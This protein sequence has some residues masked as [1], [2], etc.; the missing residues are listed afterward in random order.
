M[1]ALLNF[2]LST[3]LLLAPLMTCVGVG[4]Y[5]GR[6][7][8]PFGGPFITILVTTVTTPA[9]VFHT[10]ATTRIESALWVDLVGGTLLALLLCALLSALALRLCRL[11]VRNLL[12]TASMPNAG[13]LGLPLAYL[14][15][16]DI[17]LSA[18]VVFFAVTSF[19]QNTVM[20][21]MLSGS[22]GPGSWRSPIIL[23][24]VAA[25]TLRTLDAP[26]PQWLL[27][28]AR[29]LGS[30]TVPLM[31]I[32]LGHALAQ[33]PSSGLRTGALVGGLRLLAGMAAGYTAATA[34]GLQSALAGVLALQTAM[35]CA[36]VSYMYAQRYTN[37]SDVSAGAVLVSTV[38]FLALAP[39]LLWL[40]GSG[41]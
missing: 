9:L 29:L 4:V 33:I 31:L 37:V 30:V 41:V 2:Y 20:V 38:V 3:L 25:A 5:W 18:A 26:V 24:C 15:F 34:M 10:L 17:G 22:A 7:G 21:R 13:N 23:S 32:S 8:Q 11:P 27:E 12:P 14:A 35:P 28:S 19:V 40:A 1:V 36:V 6:K 16:G 39:V